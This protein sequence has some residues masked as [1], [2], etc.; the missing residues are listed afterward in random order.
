[1]RTPLPHGRIKPLPQLLAGEQL[2]VLVDGFHFADMNFS[3]RLAEQPGATSLFAGTEEESLM[4]G[5]PWLLAVQRQS[6]A[7]CRQLIALER[8][9]AA[10]SWIYAAFDTAALA[11]HLQARLNLRLP[12][13]RSALLRFWDPRVLAT[14][15]RRLDEAQRIAFFHSIRQWHFV[16]DGRPVHIGRD[17]A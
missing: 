3:V 9:R 13:G 7:L 8:S 14:L 16:V 6:Y 15:A 5:G 10:V 1:M 11:A 4:E 17:H 2:H 12:D